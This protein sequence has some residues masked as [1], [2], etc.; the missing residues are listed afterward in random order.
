MS[1]S[2]ARFTDCVK[3]VPVHQFDSKS[4]VMQAL[5]LCSLGVLSGCEEAT[6]SGTPGGISGLAFF[7]QNPVHVSLFFLPCLIVHGAFWLIFAQGKVHLQESAGGNA[8]RSR[9]R[10]FACRLQ[11]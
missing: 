5:L 4:L 3:T 11:F 6:E 9:Q 1:A 10:L 8:K 2:N 7:V